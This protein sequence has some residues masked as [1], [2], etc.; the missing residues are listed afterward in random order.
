MFYLFLTQITSSCRL[1]H[2]FCNIKLKYL[3]KHCKQRHYIAWCRLHT[4]FSTVC[5]SNTTTDTQTNVDYWK[6][7]IA[8]F[9]KPEK[10]SRPESWLCP[11][12]YRN[13]NI[14][15]S[16]NIIVNYLFVNVEIIHVN[17]ILFITDVHQE[18][19]EKIELEHL[20]KSVV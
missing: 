18:E 6:Y 10:Y 15:V 16:V 20:L 13:S 3:P 1:L 17:I 12:N 11:F 5:R 19:R 8:F 7:N 4:I 14:T 2:S 9:F